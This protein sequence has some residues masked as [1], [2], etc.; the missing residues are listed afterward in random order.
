M[1]VLA[2]FGL[3]QLLDGKKNV[4]SGFEMRNLRGLSF[5]Y[6]SPSCMLRFRRRLEGTPE[7]LKSDDIYSMAVILYEIITQRYPWR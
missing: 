7:D 6:A 3:S 1:A 5:A 2:D 4:V